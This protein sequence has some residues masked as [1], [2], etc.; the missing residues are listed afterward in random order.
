M[1]LCSFVF[2]VCKVLDLCLALPARVVPF[3]QMYSWGFVSE[4]F[5]H[6]NGNG[7]GNSNGGQSSSSQL[8]NGLETSNDFVPHVVRVSLTLL[9]KVKKLKIAITIN[10]VERLNYHTTPESCNRVWHKST[11]VVPKYF[12]P[13]FGKF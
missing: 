4:G 8:S 5:R 1:L 3:F 6:N 7:D 2:Q 10:F 11:L 13:I 9:E 12:S